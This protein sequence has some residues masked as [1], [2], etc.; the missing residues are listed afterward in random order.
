MHAAGVIVAPH[1][2]GLANLMFAGPVPVL[3]LFGDRF[4]GFYYYLAQALGQRHEHLMG[5]GLNRT[6]DFEIGLAQLDAAVS[7]LVGHFTAPAFR[8]GAAF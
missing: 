7:R 5:Q 4:R 3:E 8:R 2:A 6:G 1:G